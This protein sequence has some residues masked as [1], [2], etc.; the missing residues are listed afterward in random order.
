MVF[1]RRE[2]GMKKLAVLVLIALALA[3][4]GETTS[5]K[6]TQPQNTVVYGPGLGLTYNEVMAGMDKYFPKMES[7]KLNTG[8]SRRMGTSRHGAAMLEVVGDFPGE[9]IRADV[10]FMA[11][12]DSAET[13]LTSVNIMGRFVQNIFPDWDR[14]PDVMV[15]ELT[16]LAKTP[17]K[18][19]VSNAH[20]MTY[21]NKRIHLGFIKQ[22]GMF[23]VAVSNIAAKEN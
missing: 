15:Q 2:N 11:I 19:G 3:G 1:K 10:S 7:S 9:A 20:E 8:E 6:A 12:S 21:G 14:G 23:T 4:C 16:K 5:S 18:D 13:N 22:F 17:P